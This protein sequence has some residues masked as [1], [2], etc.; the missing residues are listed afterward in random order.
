MLAKG[1]SFKGLD[2][3]GDVITDRSQYAMCFNIID[4]KKDEMAPV[5]STCGG[6][7]KSNSRPPLHD[8]QVPPSGGGFPLP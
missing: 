1:S 5:N 4:T 6:G 8:H 7:S 2:W 3:N